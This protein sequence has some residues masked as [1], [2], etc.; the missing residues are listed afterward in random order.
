MFSN[1]NPDIYDSQMKGF[2][3]CMMFIGAIFG[4]LTKEIKN[5]EF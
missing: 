1:N 4:L 5:T 3:V 2:L